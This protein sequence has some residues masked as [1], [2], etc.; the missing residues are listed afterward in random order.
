MSREVHVRFCE[1]AGVRFPR[2]THLVVLTRQQDQKLS[3]FIE[4]KIETW[5]GLEINREKT[6]V[7]DLREEGASLDF[8]GFTFRYD[9]DLYGRNKRYLNLVPAKKA[10]DRERGVLREMTGSKRNFMPI[11]DLIRMLNCHLNGW[12]NYFRL[13]HPRMAFRKIN[14]YVR[15]RLA[16][17]LRRRSQRPFRLPGG[18]S[19]YELFDQLGLMNL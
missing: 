19:F 2:A 18:V 3:A 10:L 12:A 13:G 8:L 1:G 14:W 17:H 6:R 11:P 9:R 7:V 15:Y 4:E 16:R 5:M